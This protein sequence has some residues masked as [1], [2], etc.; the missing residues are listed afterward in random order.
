[1]LLKFTQKK[2]KK[3]MIFFVPA[4]GLKV[5]NCSICSPLETLKRSLVPEIPTLWQNLNCTK[6]WRVSLVGM[7]L[8]QICR[9]LVYQCVR[10]ANRMRHKVVFNEGFQQNRRKI[11]QAPQHF[12]VWRHLRRQRMTPAPARRR[13]TI[14]VG[15]FSLGPKLN[16]LYHKVFMSPW[17][18]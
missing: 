4:F 7:F 17:N 9:C 16:W 2:K 10:I 8:S 14:W 1:M 11:V 15:V 18:R 13:G 3:M 5:S 6:N 12:S